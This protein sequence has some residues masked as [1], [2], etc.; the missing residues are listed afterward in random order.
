MYKGIS[1]Y[2]EVKAGKDR[3]RQS[4]KAFKKRVEDCQGIYFV[5]T[6]FDSFMEQFSKYKTRIDLIA[7]LIKE[8]RIG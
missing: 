7:H 1:L 3:M 2:V 6:S 4:Q 5:A 8:V